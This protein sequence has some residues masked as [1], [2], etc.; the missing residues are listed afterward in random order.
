MERYLIIKTHVDKQERIRTSLF[1]Y[2]NYEEMRCEYFKFIEKLKGQ[3]AFKYSMPM[4]EFDIEEFGDV[5][6][7]DNAY[8]FRDLEGY[9]NI[10]FEMRIINI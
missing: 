10:R 9:N 1:F 6:I 5:D 4:E 3:I 8:A 2:S 7:E